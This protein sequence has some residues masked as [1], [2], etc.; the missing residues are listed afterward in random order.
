MNYKPKKG[1]ESMLYVHCY[2]MDGDNYF[3]CQEH[4]I[5]GKK[6]LKT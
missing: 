4:N 6:N 2:Q 3:G 1:M 5:I